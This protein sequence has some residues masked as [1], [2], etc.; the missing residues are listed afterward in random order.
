MPTTDYT[1][2]RGGE[3]RSPLPMAFAAV[4]AA[5]AAFIVGGFVLIITVGFGAVVGMFIGLGV[6]AATRSLRGEKLGPSGDE[7]LGVDV[8]SNDTPESAQH[9]EAGFASPSSRS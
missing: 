2:E 3:I 6:I 1:Q 8:P 4:G 5:I 9:Q 7:G